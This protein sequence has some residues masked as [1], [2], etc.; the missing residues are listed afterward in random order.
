M[1]AHGFAEI[2]CSVE[3]KT[4]LQDCAKLSVIQVLY[5]EINWKFIIC[6]IFFSIKM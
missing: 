3:P 2:K 4:K 5:Q 6:M 1:P